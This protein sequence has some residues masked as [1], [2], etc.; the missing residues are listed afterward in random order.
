MMTKQNCRKLMKAWLSSLD[1][2]SYSKLSESL[3]DNLNFFLNDLHVIQEK[4][5]IGAF[6]PLSDEPLWNLKLSLEIQNLLAF[7]FFN[8]GQKVMAFKASTLS[9]LE[10][11]S[12]FG[13][14][15][16]SPKKEALEVV[17]KVLLIPGLAFDREG[18]RLGRGRGFYDK[19]LSDFRGIKIG[20]CFDGQLI[21]QVPSEEH[22][23][24][25]DLVITNK[26]L[27]KIK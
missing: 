3:S 8:E 24:K 13:V 17:P 16:L 7:P 5:M 4:K 23:M 21:E 25:V 15:I 22:D 1:K 2:E 26:E 6:A 18:R 27:I 9:D 11:R 14:P 19:F 20:I 10:L 12:D